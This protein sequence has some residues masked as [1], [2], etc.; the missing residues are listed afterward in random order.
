MK[1][2]IT[3]LIAFALCLSLSATAFAADLEAQ[4][5]AEPQSESEIEPRL[6]EVEWIYRV[7]N[8]N[9]EKRLWSYTE[10]VWLT[11]WLYVG[12]AT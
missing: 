8:G 9:I 3:L 11:D 5:I 12:P 6:E 1:K 2:F 4:P 7:Y 10:G